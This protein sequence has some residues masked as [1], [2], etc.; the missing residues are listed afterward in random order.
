MYKTDLYVN[1]RC[2][3]NSAFGI[4]RKNTIL[5]FTNVKLDPN[6]KRMLYLLHNI[7]IMPQNGLIYLKCLEYYVKHRNVYN[8]VVLF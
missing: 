6:V 4:L 7:V 1:N 2:Y 8:L 3:V 5:S